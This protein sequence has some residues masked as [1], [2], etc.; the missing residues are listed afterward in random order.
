MKTPIN[1]MLL[2]PALIAGLEL[3]PLGPLG[4]QT[5]TTLYS[6]HGGSDGGLP[7]AG[8]ILDGNTLYGTTT[9]GGSANSGTIFK[10][11]T[12]GTGFT[13]LHIFTAL[14]SPPFGGTNGDGAW[15]MAGLVFSSNILYGTTHSGGSG[16]AGT[17]FAV[18]TDGSGFTNLHTFTAP[19]VN[20]VN[21]DGAYAAAGLVLSGGALYGTAASGGSFGFGTLFALNADGTGFTNLHSFAGGNGGSD[22]YGG[23]LLSGSALFGT[24]SDGGASSNGTVFAINTSGSGFTN[25]YSFTATSDPSSGTN[26]DGAAPQGGLILSGD[27]LYGTTYGGG[28][29]GNGTVF[30][31]KT[32]GGGFANLHN[33]TATS[34]PDYANS[35]GAW[36]YAT[37]VLS[38][39]ALYGTTYAGGTFGGGTAFAVTA[40][41][42]GFTN[43]HSFTFGNDGSVPIASLILSGNTLYGT[44][45]YD[46]GAGNGA[47]F[48]LAFVPQL[49]I[50][51]SGTNVILSWP[52]NVAGFSYAGF[53]LQSST[54]LGPL[55]S[56][57]GVS[58]G[59]VAV[60]GQNT[61][62]NPISGPRKLY[63]LSQ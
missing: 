50:R 57:T 58:P 45:E 3:I 17:V 53:N 19:G 1:N 48:S 11:K 52:T 23:L 47:I 42:T 54:N 40:D 56:W 24:T 30:A 2:L 9:Y 63:R 4:A 49:A 34:S 32:N 15:P 25:L 55:A 46:G 28:S 33:F 5:F 44:V 14:S 41:G 12:D 21:G 38:G 61:V 7:Q 20:D 51:P 18:K 13:N 29:A 31:V 8:L 37:L 22:P 62:T 36:P 6:F 35:D 27:I 10:V 60:S 39:K 16:G 59:P 26:S 43:L